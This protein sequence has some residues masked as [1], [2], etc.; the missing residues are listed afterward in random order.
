MSTC[1]ESNPLH[2]AEC[3]SAERLT[4]G[5]ESIE[6]DEHG[7]PDGGELGDVDERVDEQD[8]VGNEGVL[9]LFDEQHV[10]GE[11]L[12]EAG[13]EEERV[14]EDGHCLKEERSHV[15]VTIHVENNE[16]ETVAWEQP[17]VALYLLFF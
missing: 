5:D 12:G 8:D 14:V 6:S 11:D 15:T 2:G 4:D 1:L 3:S 16:R 7:D 17:N 13:R 10:G 9:A